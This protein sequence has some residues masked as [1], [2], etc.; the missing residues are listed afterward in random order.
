MTLGKCSRRRRR[1]RRHNL[2]EMHCER[3][4]NE[5][6]YR[7]NMRQTTT[8]YKETEFEQSSINE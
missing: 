1:R 6:A 2:S 3:Q 8:T 5:G 4:L 7:A